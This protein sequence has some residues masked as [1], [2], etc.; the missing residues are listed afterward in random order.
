MD[1]SSYSNGKEFKQNV[2]MNEYKNSDKVMV[3]SKTKTDV[4]GAEIDYNI[5]GFEFKK[6]RRQIIFYAGLNRF[7]ADRTSKNN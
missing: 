5:T 6:T 2:F 4:M 1:I 7:Y 3:S